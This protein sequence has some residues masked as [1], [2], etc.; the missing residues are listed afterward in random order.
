[1]KIKI[2]HDVFNIVNR[3]KTINKNYFVLFNLKTKKFELHNKSTKNTL[4]LILPFERLDARTITHVLKSEKIDECLKEI[5]I[6]NEKIS[7]SNKEK[8]EDKVKYQLKEIYDFASSKV[9]NFDGNAYKFD[10]C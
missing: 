1:M 9:K 4:C 3:L 5:E 2:E 6:V 8:L 7:K 10:W